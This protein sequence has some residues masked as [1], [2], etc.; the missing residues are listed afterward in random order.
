MLKDYGQTDRDISY[1]CLD[2]RERDF[3]ALIEEA[4][5]AIDGKIY[6]R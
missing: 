6:L 3:Y 1:I 5:K 2:I 4:E